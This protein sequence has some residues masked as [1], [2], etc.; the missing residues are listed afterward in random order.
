MLGG[1]SKNKTNVGI[2][3]V[4][5]QQTDQIDKLAEA[6]ATAQGEITGALKESANPFFKSKYADLASCWDA[7]RSA[8]SKNGLAVI[9]CPSTTESGHLNLATTL[10][11]SSGQWM[12]SD[13]SVTPKDDSPQAFGSALTYARRYA[14]TAMVGIAQVDDDGNAASGRSEGHSPKGDM[15][16]DVSPAVVQTTV[17]HMLG[18]MDEDIIGDH[19]GLKKAMIVLD[20][21]EKVL[22]PDENLYVAVG[23]VLTAAKRNAWK[24]LVSLAKKAEKDDRATDP[25]R[26]RF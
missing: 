5:M 14:L 2:R 1:T 3:N 22:N 15:G 4:S 19:D 21:H 17:K 18:L 20:Y 23:D 9:Q 24:A 7:C 25:T 10:M 12:R 6:L 11:H 16:K 26:P 8:L 13:L